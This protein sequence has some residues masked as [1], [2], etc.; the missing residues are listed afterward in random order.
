MDWTVMLPFA[1]TALVTAASLFTAL[2]PTPDPSTTWGKVYRIIERVALL[3][4]KAKQSGMIP[5]NP[6]ADKLAQEAVEAAK[7]LLGPTLAN[8]P[9]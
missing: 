3:T 4:A 6:A 1:G 7:E 5:T 2:T 9:R 8:L